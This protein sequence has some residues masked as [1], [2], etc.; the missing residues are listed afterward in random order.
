MS[1][2]KEI[3]QNMNEDNINEINKL[4]REELLKLC[5]IKSKVTPTPTKDNKD[6]RDKM[7]WTMQ[8]I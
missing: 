4:T 7:P 3:F 5:S 2:L 8:N 6:I 1:S